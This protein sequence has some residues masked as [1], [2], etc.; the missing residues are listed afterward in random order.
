MT[1]EGFAINE[2]MQAPTEDAKISPRAYRVRIKIALHPPQE[3]KIKLNNSKK[4]KI[5]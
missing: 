5:K 3:T 1:W 2:K 4:T